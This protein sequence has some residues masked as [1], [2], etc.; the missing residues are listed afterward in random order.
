MKNPEQE[1]A[2]LTAPVAPYRWRVGPIEL[3][4]TDQETG[5]VPVRFSR[6]IEI[7]GVRA[8][9]VPK[10]PLAGGALRVPTV[11]DI[12]VLV[13]LN[14]DVRLTNQV[15]DD[16]TQR[17]FVPLSS[18]TVDEATLLRWIPNVDAPDF[19]VS[20]AWRQFIQGTPVYESAIVDLVFLARYVK[21]ESVTGGAP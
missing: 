7:V 21:P 14:Q 15:N 2:T 17:G 6:P 4:N 18:L 5:F 1:Y 8:V 16:G 12:D 11:S 3:L 19:Q 9:V 13:E 20:F 10:L